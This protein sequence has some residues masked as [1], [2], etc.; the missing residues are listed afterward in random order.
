MNRP[1]HSDPIVDEDV[2]SLAPLGGLIWRYRHWLMV[3]FLGCGDE[4]G[5][6]LR[7]S[8]CIFQRQVF[9]FCCFFVSAHSGH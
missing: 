3:C 4:D 1:Q 5:G 6:R 7:V 9:S 2:I 8:A